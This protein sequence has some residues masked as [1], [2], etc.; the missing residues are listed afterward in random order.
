MKPALVVMAAGLGSRYG[1]IKQ[2]EG[3]GLAGEAIVDYSVFDALRSGF[4]KIVFI[5]RR[6]IEE[7]F[8]AFARGRFTGCDIRYVYQEVDGLP[9]GFSAPAGRVKPWGTAHAV[10]AARPEADCPFALINADDFYGRDAFR[11]MGEWL[12]G[13]D[14]SAADFAMIGYRLS[15]TLSENGSVSRGI[16]WAEGGFLLSVEEHT[17]IEKTGREEGPAIVSR[18]ESGNIP[19]TGSE[20]VS[21]NMFGFTPRLFPL[22][23]GEFRAFLETRG[24]SLTAEWYIPFA[25]NALIDRGEARMRVLPSSAA[26]FGVTYR[27]DKPAVQ[28]GIR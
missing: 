21:M 18:R 12:S 25:V 20:I 1:G 28:A 15:N 3:V 22:L 11:L 16:C 26:W 27:E 2:I 10:L 7:D 6:E 19:L 17:K 8:R 5:I 13:A 14:Y 9:P 24:D 4:G 23:E